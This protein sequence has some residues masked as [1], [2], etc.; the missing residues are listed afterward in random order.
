MT[1]ADPVAVAAIV[2]A[3]LEELGIRYVIGGSVASSLMG[4]P[5]STLDLDLMIACDA[6][7]VRRLVERLKEAFYVDESDALRAVADQSAFNAIH[8]PTSLKVDF[9]LAERAPFA[10]HQIER[11][12]AIDIGGARLY[13]YAPEDLIVRKLMWF[14]LGAETSERQWR[15]VLGILKTEKNLNAELLREAAREAGVDNLLD[16]ALQAVR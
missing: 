5:R 4:E 13:F 7:S 11:R 12:R 8:L 3:I 14:R 6:H 1:P 10:S 2:A 16:R 15:D 9:F